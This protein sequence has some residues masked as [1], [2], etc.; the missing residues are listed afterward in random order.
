VR[1]ISGRE[2]AF[3]FGGKL[4][5]G[6][7]FR[8]RILGEI[9]GAVQ[10]S[11]AAAL[12]LAD[13]VLVKVLPRARRLDLLRVDAAVV[14]RLG[15]LGHRRV[16]LWPVNLPDPALVGGVFGIGEVCLVGHRTAFQ[17]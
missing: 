2:Q 9:I 1:R 4:L 6:G 7:R 17:G 12:G 8:A 14:Q 11:L 5:V 15:R 13:R 16:K 10:N 3:I